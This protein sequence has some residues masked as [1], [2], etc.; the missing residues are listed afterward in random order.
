MKITKILFVFGSISLL[1][2]LCGISLS[3]DERTDTKKLE[4]IKIQ[5]IK[6]I[7][8]PFKKP[9]IS[10]GVFECDPD[11]SKNSVWSGK[12]HLKCRFYDDDPKGYQKSDIIINVNN[13]S[14]INGY[15]RQKKAPAIVTYTENMSFTD[16]DGCT[17]NWQANFTKQTTADVELD[18]YSDGCGWFIKWTVEAPQGTETRTDSCGSPTSVDKEHYALTCDDYMEGRIINKTI[19]SNSSKRNEEVGRGERINH[20]YFIKLRRVR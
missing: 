1:F 20:E 2:V 9:Q 3:F 19:I 16:I 15:G 13:L 5:P 6:P 8:V 12:I 4:P 17:F 7:K 18:I 10:P 14:I 11:I